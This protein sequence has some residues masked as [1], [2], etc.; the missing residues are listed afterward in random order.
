MSQEYVCCAGI[1]LGTTNSAIA[2]V[3]QHGKPDIIANNEGERI[4]PSAVVIE[5]DGVPLVGIEAVNQALIE[6]ER[7]VRLIK[8]EMGNPSYRLN[9]DGE[10]YSPET[11]S[12][13]ILQ[14]L[15]KDASERLGQDITKVAIT[16]PAYFNDAKREATRQ[17]AEIAGLEVVRIIN[18]PTAAAIAYGLDKEENQTILVYDWGGGTFDVTIMKIENRE[19]TVLAT[20]GDAR[21]GG[22]DVDAKLV[23]FLAEDFLEVH[24]IDLREEPHTL[25]DL[26]D[27]AEIA[28]KDLSFRNSTIVTLSQGEKTARVNIDRDDFNDLIEDLIAKTEDCL[29]RVIKDAG[30]NC[31]EIDKVLLVGGSTRIPLVKDTIVRV[32]GLEPVNDINPDECVAMGAAIQAVI[33]MQD[34]PS[35]HRQDLDEESA[36][37]LD[38]V[39]ESLDIQV[40]DVATHSLGVKAFSPSRNRYVN[41]IIIPRLTQIPCEFTKIYRTSED[42]QQRVQFDV[43]QGEEE[44]PR[45]PD[46][47]RIGKAGLRDLP[48]HQ[49]G[50]LFLEVTLRYT[51]DGTVEVITKEQQSGKT[52]RE[53]VMPKTG[54]LS[55]EII[56]QQKEKLA[57]MV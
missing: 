35:E 30:I 48:P 43:L 36:L 50:E 53:V 13:F 54:T 26:R 42:N 28:K 20:D 9:I 6:P 3:N 40:I 25:Q 7:T 49:V 10:E 19:F 23:D 34:T 39:A 8:R 5:P 56:Q 18:E 44:N 4:T 29:N 47:D 22:A 33:G 31:S 17:A 21:L 38:E 16:T 45:S 46:V 24:D 2:V 1:D 14:K 32:T 12:A 55:P 57:Q 27:K 11:I 52:S 37:V 51:V 41:S 15:V